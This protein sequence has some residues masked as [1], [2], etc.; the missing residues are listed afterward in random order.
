M[1][2]LIFGEDISSQPLPPEDA[3]LPPEYPLLYDA[4]ESVL[5]PDELPTGE[6]PFADEKA[7]PADS[8]PKR[9]RNLKQL[10]LM[11]VAASLAAVSVLFASVSYD[12]LGMD[13][14]NSGSSSSSSIPGADSSFPSLTNLKPNGN[15][16]NCGVLDEEFVRLEYSS[17]AMDWLVA[18]KAYNSSGITTTTVSGITY[19]AS[20]NTIV[21]NNYTGTCALNINLMG[22]GLKLQLNG[23]NQIGHLLVWGFGYGGSLTITGSGTLTVNPDSAFAYGIYLKGEASQTCLMI[24]RTVQID[25]YGSTAA[26]YV[27]D[28]TMTQGVYYLSPLYAAGGERVLLPSAVNGCYDYSFR[29]PATEGLATHMQ[30]S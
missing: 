16:P 5:P 29:D 24:D 25:A 15:V 27:E 3:P 22:N 28:T 30:F 1:D 20:T 21:M 13:L 26:V 14:F 4:S 9:H 7:A 10:F 2:D 8:A 23:T 17:T 6:G 12:P 18:G 19:D 11:P